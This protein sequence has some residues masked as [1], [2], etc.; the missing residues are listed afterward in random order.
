MR[1]TTQLS[2]QHWQC[3]LSH[4]I[5]WKPLELEQHHLDTTHPSFVYNV[6]L[7]AFHTMQ[8]RTPLE[9]CSTQCFQTCCHMSPVLAKLLDH[10]AGELTKMILIQ[11]AEQHMLGMYVH[12]DC[13]FRSADNGVASK[14]KVQH[15]QP[16]VRHR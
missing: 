12:V 14:S 15:L 8:E 3:P 2:L 5:P 13:T 7:R 16:P 4:S 6:P 9:C 1:A 10:R 11:L